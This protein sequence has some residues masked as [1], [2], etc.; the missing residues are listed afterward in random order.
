[1]DEDEFDSIFAAMDS[2]FFSEEQINVAQARIQ[3]RGRCYN[4]GKSAT[5]HGS[6]GIH[7]D[8]PGSTEQQEHEE[9]HHEEQEL[10]SD[11]PEDKEDDSRRG[12]GQVGQGLV[13]MEIDQR[14][15]RATSA[16][17][18]A[19][20]QGLPPRRASTLHSL[21]RSSNQ[22]SNQINHR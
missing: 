10:D 19:P 22:A 12:Q 14:H 5:W 21:K 7:L 20:H 16:V 15:G 18:W 1:M 3:R 4:C 2:G 11:K 13:D 6:A 17:R 9:D 8:D